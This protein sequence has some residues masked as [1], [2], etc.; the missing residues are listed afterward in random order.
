AFLAGRRQR[1]RW[2]AGRLA[3]GSSREEYPDGFAV[4]HPDAATRRLMAAAAVAMEIVRSDRLQRLPGR[5]RPAGD[6]LVADWEV[7]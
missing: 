7:K 6:D 1:P 4:P 5:L 2:R 3:T